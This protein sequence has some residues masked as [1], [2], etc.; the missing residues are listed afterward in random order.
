[1]TK[2]SFIFFGILL[3]VIGLTSKGFTQTEIP[4]MVFVP[5]P[6]G[7]KF[8]MGTAQGDPEEKPKNTV[9]L[10]EGFYLDKTEV[11]AE[12]YAAC[13]NNKE[14]EKRCPEADLDSPGCNFDNKTWKPKPG[15]EKHPINC[16][17]YEQAET[18]CKL[19]NK[20]LPTGIE[21][22]Y[23]ARGTKESIYPWGNDSPVPNS[24]YQ[25]PKDPRTPNVCW[26][27]TREEGT[28]PVGSYPNN[29]TLLGE[30]NP[31]G[32]FDLAGNVQEWV[33]ESIFDIMSGKYLYYPEHRECP[34][35]GYCTIRGGDFTADSSKT[36]RL[37]R[38]SFRMS[39]KRN[40][41][42]ANTGFRCAKNKP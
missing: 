36:S 35:Q 38:S 41:G 40:F 16:V 6:K 8:T 37:L 9:E 2:N 14:K 27:R 19:A 17:N 22:E 1:M 25:N 39:I 34:K 13:V 23:A 24:P 10:T 11:T 29:A 12:D 31:Q 4:G 18:Y 15:K 32:I 5:P 28:C 7:G 21:W 42:K 26:D 3:G 20:R 30:K 33:N